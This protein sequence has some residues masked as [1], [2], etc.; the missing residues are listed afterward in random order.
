MEVL[1]TGMHLKAIVVYQMHML[2]RCY[3]RECTSKL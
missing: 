2:C 3:K 1:L